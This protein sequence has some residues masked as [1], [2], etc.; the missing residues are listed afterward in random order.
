VSRAGVVLLAV[1]LAPPAPAAPARFFVAGDGRLALVHAHTGAHVD[2]RYRRADGTYDAAAV[3]A[4]RRALRSAG[5]TGDGRAAL[6][7]VELLGRVQGMAGGRP[8]RIQSGYRSP[9]Y[10][11]AIRERGARAAGGS[12]HTEGLAADVAIPRPRLRDVWLRLRALDCCGAG[13][14]AKDGFLHV[15]AGRPRFWEA[16]TSRVAENL[17][18][19]NARL[20]ARTEYD[21]YPAGE[22]I[23]VTLHALTAPPVRVARAARLVGGDAERPLVV[24]AALAERDG[25]Y[26]VPATGTALDLRGAPAGARGRVVLDTCAPREGATPA[27]VETNR[28]EVR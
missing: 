25:C 10:N 1:A 28:V 17:S 15:D 24:E 3:A 27:R 16:A 21:R 8:L 7:L 13:Y 9:A 19:A 4:I 5:D 22:P 26:E 11:E 14:Y 23:A 12:L 18:A 20:F 2:V 6:R